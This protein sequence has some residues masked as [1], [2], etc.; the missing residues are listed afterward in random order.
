MKRIFPR[1]FEGLRVRP[2]DA[3]PSKLLETLE[4]IAPPGAAEKPTVVLL[5][6]GMGNSAYF[7]H[8]FLAQ[9]MGIQLVEGGDLAVEGGM[10]WMRTTKGLRRVDVIYRR[11]D[12]DFL[13]PLAFR[14]DSLLGVPGLLSVYRAGNVALAN[15]PGNGVADDKVVYAYVPKIIRYYLDEDPIL[16]NVPTFLCW[17]EQ[18]RKHVLQNLEK[19]VVKAANEAGGYGMLVGP[20]STAQQREEFAAKIV[21]S[22]RNYV[23]QPTLA[24]SRVPTLVE[25]RLEGRHVDLRPYILHG[26]E[27]NVPPGGLTRVAL[28]KGSLVVNSSQGGGSKDTWVLEPAPQEGGV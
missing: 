5:T 9:Q 17:F 16:P 2:V 7:E 25:D 28:R 14:P 20:H 3:Y 18:D 11:I 12:D 22:P 13:D 26:K 19:F 27:I 1:V 24:L 21:A 15:A 10:V 4:A 6:P 23:A 8:S